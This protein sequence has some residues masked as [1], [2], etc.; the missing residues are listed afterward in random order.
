SAPGVSILSTY[1]DDAYAT[2]SGTSM[3][4]PHVAGVAALVWAGNPVDQN[5]DGAVNQVDV[6][7]CLQRTALD[8]GTAG[9]DSAYGFGRVRAEAAV[10]ACQS[11]PPVETPPAAPSNLKVT[12]TG[13]NYVNLAWQDN[14]TNETGF[15]VERCTGT[16]CTN[17]A[18]VASL[19][20]NT[21]SYTDGGLARKTTYRYRV[22][23]RNSAGPSSYSNEVTATTK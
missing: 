10:A 6:R 2:A 17:F 19:G 15:E 14:S 13:R 21:T 7:L 12:A 1:P 9:R 4:S 8:L 3:A 5:G 16:G 22:R 20:A 11:L 23:A 18:L